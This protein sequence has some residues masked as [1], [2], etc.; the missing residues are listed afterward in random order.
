MIPPTKE[1][2]TRSISRWIKDN[3][4]DAATLPPE[5]LSQRATDLDD[6]MIEAF[7]ARE[8]EVMD[9]LM[10]SG[11]WGTEE[12]ARQFRGLKSNLVYGML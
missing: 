1:V 12:G 8:D 4:Q 5:A 11:Q 10:K 2:R 7:E 6:Q 3:S 9:R